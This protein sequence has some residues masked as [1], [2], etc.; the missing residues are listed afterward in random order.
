MVRVHLY[1]SLTN[2]M[3]IYHPSIEEEEEKDN[4]R[5]KAKI[6]AKLRKLEEKE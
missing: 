6:K 5:K 3:N 1:V 4:K 2:M